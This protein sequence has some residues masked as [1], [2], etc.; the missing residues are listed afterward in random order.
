MTL[1]DEILAIWLLVAITVFIYANVM[2][3]VR[4]NKLPK[5]EKKPTK[6]YPMQVLDK[7]YYFDS[8]EERDAF[9]LNGGHMRVNEEKTTV[10]K[11]RWL[12][13]LVDGVGM[14]AEIDG[15]RKYAM[16]MR[17]EIGTREKIIEQQKE[18]IASLQ[19]A[20]Q[21]AQKISESMKVAM[22]H[23]RAL[24]VAVEQQFKHFF[25]SVDELQR[26]LLKALEKIEQQKR[27]IDG[28]PRR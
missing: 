21:E 26:E 5:T 18:E 8:Q 20:C 24:R 19:S 16:N 1:T 3:W 9:I 14:Q 11:S 6:K 15:L 2:G 17:E 7:L 22:L 25:P 13:W 10:P 23:E 27:E 12:G 4:F 28:I